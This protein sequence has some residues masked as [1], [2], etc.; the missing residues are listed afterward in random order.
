MTTTKNA[1]TQTR[2]RKAA[3]ET[4]NGA[5]K[6]NAATAAGFGGFALPAFDFDLMVEAG[7]RN[8]EAVLEAN[9]IAFDGCHEV[10]E[11]QMEIARELIDEAQ[12]ATRSL[13]SGGTP[14]L[15][16]GT[17]IERA[18]EQVRKQLEN[19]RSL[20]ELGVRTQRET[21]AVL[22]RRLEESVEEARRLQ[23]AA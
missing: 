1:R 21:L 17:Q 5:E 13:F 14:E 15:D 20:A 19:W 23:Q 2:T 8:V 18:Q 12:E 7:R 9:R 3:K 4:G 22:A 6:R 10:L 11:R 16:A